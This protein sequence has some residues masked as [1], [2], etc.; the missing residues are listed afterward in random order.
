LSPIRTF[1]LGPFQVKRTFWKVFFSI[2]F[3]S[4]WG[5]QPAASGEFF[6][7][8]KR[9]SLEK[10]PKNAQYRHLLKA[11]DL[12]SG[13]ERSEVFGCVS[14]QHV[15]GLYKKVAEKMRSINISR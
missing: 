12:N 14:S 11:P 8:L 15:V 9:V 2:Q 1:S 5:F 10:C 6:V 4:T 13:T 7:E 3:A